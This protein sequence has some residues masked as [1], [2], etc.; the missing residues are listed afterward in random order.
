MVLGVGMVERL[1]PHRPCESVPVIPAT[2]EPEKLSTTNH[3][4]THSRDWEQ[5]DGTLELRWKKALSQG[6]LGQ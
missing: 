5:I 3:Y 1:S 4:L 2:I 6:S